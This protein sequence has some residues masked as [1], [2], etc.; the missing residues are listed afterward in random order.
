MTPLLLA[1]NADALLHAGGR[2]HPVL[3]HFPLGLLLSAAAYETLNLI[4]GK[5]TL[6]APTAV[7]I[8]L[9]ALGAVA[10][11]GTG[12]INGEYEPHGQ[13]VA[14]LLFRHRWLG[15]AVAVL[16]TLLAL[17][18]AFGR[19]SPS[20]GQRTLQTATL[21]GLAGLTGLTGHLGGSMVYGEDYIFEPLRE[22][23]NAPKTR[24]P[25]QATAPVSLPAGTV[26]DFARDIRPI[27]ESRCYT[28]HGPEK[29]K[30][31]LRLDA[32]K[33][34]FEGDPK[35]WVI[36]VGNSAGSELVRRLE[37]PP[38]DEEHMPPKDPPLS[39]LQIA[40]IKAWIDQQAP[41]PE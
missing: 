8:V 37:L 14:T 4:R 16:S 41:W 27:F 22:A 9:G 30:G 19:T 17:S 26:V 31:N 20:R 13:A 35:N 40:Q 18:L 1:F 15:V 10:A 23:F 39:G 6:A 24:L 11:A 5:P 3:V 38:D 7:M 12:W 32:R 33:F 2:L 25:S 34:V 36:C 29:Q 21:L 28:C